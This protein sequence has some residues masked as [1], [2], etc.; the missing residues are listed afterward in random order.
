MSNKFAIRVEQLGKRYYTPQRSHSHDGAIKRHLKNLGLWRSSEDD[1]FWALRDVSFEVKPGEILGILGKN[2]SGKSTLLK[3]LSG[4]TPPSTGRAEINGRIGSLLE[5]GTG[6]HPDMSGR[7]NIYMNGV[8]LGIPKKEIDKQFDELVDFSG[9]EEFIDVP[10]KRYSSGMYVRLAY[11]VASKLRSDILILDEVLAVGD[12][13]FQDKARD[14][15][16]EMTASGRTILI[17]P[18]QLK[19]CNFKQGK[20]IIHINP[21][22]FLHALLILRK[23]L[24]QV[25]VVGYWAWELEEIP[26]IWKR[27]LLFVDEVESP[28]SFTAQAIQKQTAKKVC[29]HPHA[30]NLDLPEKQ[31]SFAEDGVVRVLFIFDMGSTLARKNPLAAIRAFQQA[32]GKKSK[33]H[34]TLKAVGLSDTPD[35]KAI[36]DQIAG[37]ENITCISSILTNNEIRN[38]FLSHDIYLSLH[39][40]EGYGLT[41]REAMLHGLHVVGTGWSGNMDFLHGDKCHPVPYT[42]LEIR[43]HKGP[44]RINKARWAEADIDIAANVLREICQK[45]HFY[46]SENNI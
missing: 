3:I 42:L 10:V 26:S 40:S 46:L 4:V 45:E 15:I 39:R 24:P 36:I 22:M 31:R 23:L 33:A 43:N 2:G 9:I 21:P 34:F 44:F 1:H 29:I 7:E 38:L 8:L 35:S 19:Q 11:A 37:W 32:F 18:N 20:L 14:N 28:S 27:S 16:K 12:V 30:V 17:R 13:A 25:R 41:L 6:F 5:V